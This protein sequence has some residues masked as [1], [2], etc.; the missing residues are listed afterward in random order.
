[1]S[2]ASVK[3]GSLFALGFHSSCCCRHLHEVLSIAS[4]AIAVEVRGSAFIPL[5][6]IMLNT[7]KNKR[8]KKKRVQMRDK[9][10]KK[11]DHSH[12]TLGYEMQ[13]IF[14]DIIFGIFPA[15]LEIKF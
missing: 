4:L 5:V 3:D 2:V 8:K 6:F 7:S 10:N 12:Y 11:K 9:R 13:Y 1:V 15:V 14:N